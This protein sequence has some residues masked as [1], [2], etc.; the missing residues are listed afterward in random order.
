MSASQISNLESP[1]APTRRRGL[2]ILGNDVVLEFLVAL[3][4][5]LRHFSPDIPA[6]LIPYDNR[7]EKLRPWL[8][9]YDITLHDDPDFTFYD[10]LGDELWDVTH[11]GHHM[12]RKFAAFSGPFDD[13]L[14][15]DADIAVLAPVEKL[16]DE[17]T[18]SGADFL[19]FDADLDNVYKPT[20][21]RDALARSGRTQGFTAGVFLARGG[22]FTRADLTT[23]LA[24]AKCDRAY[25]VYQY[26]QPF[27]NYAVDMRGLRQVRLTHFNSVYPDKL[28]GDQVPI[29][30]RDGAWRLLTPGHAD[31]G[32]AIPLIHWAG[33]Q[34]G[35]RF[36]NRHVFYHFR[37]LGESLPMR[38]A[39]RAA[40]HWRWRV[41][42]PWKKFKNWSAHKFMRLRME[43]GKFLPRRATP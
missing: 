1:D 3:F 38:L 28:W 2:Y 30:H 27:F 39:Y 31:F 12:F 35:D 29:A 37:L 20:P 34:G 40:D 8:Q 43:L 5:S 32:K 33:H 23:L 14:Y 6:R 18:R 10:R 7:L 15:L 42:R 24:D 19:T 41:A 17:F 36:P 21:W 25:F 22:L 9:R 11:L 13:F 16:F 4:R 26:D